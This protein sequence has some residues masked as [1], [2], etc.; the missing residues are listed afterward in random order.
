MK[1]F[2]YSRAA[3]CGQIITALLFVILVTHGTE[4][5]TKGTII[6]NHNDI[7][8]VIGGFVIL[9]PFIGEYFNRFVEFNDEYAVFNS[10]RIDKKVRHFNVRYEDILSLEATKIPLLGIYKVKVKA[11]NVPYIIPVT[12]CMKK[13]HKLFYNLCIYAKKYNPNVYID[14]CLIEQLEKK[15]YYEKI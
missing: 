3:F 11:K 6:F 4:L 15:G 10:F 9:A 5:F 8:A 2:R 14:S 13:H 7:I 12:W 1:K